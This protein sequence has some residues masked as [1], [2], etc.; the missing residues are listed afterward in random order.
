VANNSI[1]LKESVMVSITPHE[2]EA[3]IMPPNGHYVRVNRILFLRCTN[4]T[5]FAFKIH[6]LLPFNN[7]EL[8]HFKVIMTPDNCTVS[9][10]VR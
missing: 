10:F 3:V 8:C 4:F 6:L 9:Q 5:I 2:A 7:R 1:L